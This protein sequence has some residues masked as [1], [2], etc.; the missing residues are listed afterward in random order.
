[1]QVGGRKREGG[2]RKGARKGGNQG[3]R[4][5]GE[6]GDLQKLPKLTVSICQ[7]SPTH[8]YHQEL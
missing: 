8:T 1:M 2:G 7:P 6:K 5:A 4:V 3:G